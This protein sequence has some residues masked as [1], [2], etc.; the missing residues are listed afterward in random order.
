RLIPGG[1][2]GSVYRQRARWRDRLAR[3]LIS[4]S[5]VGIICTILGIGLFLCLEVWPLLL[6]ARVS[7]PLVIP[8]FQ[9]GEPAQFVRV[10]EHQ[11]RALVLDAGPYLVL[12]DLL[13]GT[14]LDRLPLSGLAADSR[15]AAVS[16]TG[17]HPSVA[18]AA[19][20]GTVWVGAVRLNTV[21]H[22]TERRIEPAVESSSILA[23]PDGFTPRLLAH[24][25]DDSG[26]LLA[27]VGGDAT[28]HLI[29][30]SIRR[31]LIG[32][33]VIEQFPQTLTIDT[34][35]RISAVLVNPAMTELVLGTAQGDLSRWR[36]DRDA[37]IRRLESVPAVLGAGISALGYALG[38][39]SLVVGGEDGSV[40]AW[41]LLPAEAS[42][43][44]RSLTRT[45]AFPS[46]LAA[47]T[48]IAASPR[49]KGFVT[50]SGDGT[51][52][53]AYLTTERV[54]ASISQ[55]GPAS[56]MAV[57]PKADGLVA[58][59][60]DGRLRLWRIQN[61]HPDVSWQAL[62][63]NVQYEGYA[64]PE[65]IWQSHAGTDDFEP[66]YSLVPL[67]FGTLKGTCYAM[68]FSVP[69]AVLGALYA[70]LFLHR[71]LRAPVKGA[72]ELMAALPSVVLGFVA[73]LVL[74]PFAE[75]HSVAMLL[76][77]AGV[78]GSAIVLVWVMWQLT[79]PRAR[80]LLRQYEFFVIMAGAA[81]GA[82]LALVLGPAIE[83]AA[84]GGD[85]QVWL[86]EA[87]GMRYDQRN[88]LIVGLV[89][90]FAVIPIIF[91]ICE[92]AFSSVP[93]HLI[94]ASLACGATMW[95]TAVKV[96][97]PAAGSGVFSAIMIGFGRA[98]GETMIVLMAT[99]NT[100]I[101]SWSPFN[102]F[103]A[104]SANIAVEIPEAPMGSTHYRVLFVAA[105]V[106]FA[107]T[108]VVNTGS[109]LIRMRLR[110]RL[111]GI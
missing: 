32:S 67:I 101:M 19:Y 92:D 61:P 6:G 74:A 84:F 88:A 22:G 93:A 66:K 86:L 25:W 46:H 98:V 54:L 41:S 105:L 3:A 4:A 2:A 10:D 63:G 82:G 57:A 72:I 40:V 42:A 31:P 1:A 59:G 12:V 52:R 99:G 44:G 26:G 94:G 17:Y 27:A 104:L 79:G 70:A 107:M 55:P 37:T 38:G 36:I 78:V 47:V 18:V 30:V 68:L 20:D 23:L 53:L 95:Q 5:G 103:R 60:A 24:Q 14:T 28:L 56:A 76:M 49:D 85:F 77:P 69:L 48:N 33:P 89:M 50:A 62:F 15:I 51:L 100:A 43:D 75:R 13:R 97:L 110:K 35:G 21:F 111:A 7:A 96:V 87:A 73:G 80:P 9:T 108:F 83:Q 90:G 65:Y 64:A 106:L 39:R 102:G 34:V 8:G 29:R 58:V 11:E 71:R 45:H 81:A 16:S 91:T 109:E